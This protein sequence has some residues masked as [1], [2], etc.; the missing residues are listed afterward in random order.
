[1]ELIEFRVKAMLHECRIAQTK[2]T[3]ISQHS[4][5]DGRVSAF[6]QVLRELAEIQED[7]D[8]SLRETLKEGEV[9]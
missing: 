9:P 1:M 5:L 3:R 7:W 6:E 4:Y 2:A 8:N